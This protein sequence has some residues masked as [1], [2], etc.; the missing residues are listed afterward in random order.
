MT[1][2]PPD[3]PTRPSTP[4]ALAATAPGAR[5]VVLDAFQAF[6]AR[7][8]GT[9]SWLYLDVKGLVT[10]GVGNLV[11][12]MPA[13]LDL[14]WRRQ[15]GSLAAPSEV[16]EAWQVVKHATAMQR[17]GG[18][19]FARLTTLRL[20]EAGIA[21]LVRQRLTVDD[22]YLA[23]RFASADYADWPADAQLGILSMAWAMGPAFQFPLFAAA[24]ERQ[25]FAAAAKQCG[26][27]T[28]G[29]SGVA[30]R[31]AANVR[32]FENAAAVI[33]NGWDREQLWYPVVAS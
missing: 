20:D 18:F 12:P 5:Q 9:C 24:V 10:T 14:P 33:A 26:I 19:A 7:F 2:P 6:T 15:D 29:N 23:R 1:Q 11:D 8:E 28:A 30:P 21:A 25:D 27:D 16:E 4:L 17:L 22:Q 31:N 3:T 32:C 13:A